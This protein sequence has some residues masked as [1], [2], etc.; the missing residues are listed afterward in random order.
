MAE[1]KPDDKRNRDE[2]SQEE[3]PQDTQPENQPGQ[4][5]SSNESGD[6]LEESPTGFVVVDPDTN[7]VLESSLDPEK[8]EDSITIGVNEDAV[9][10]QIDDYTDDPDVLNDFAERQ[11]AA[12]VGS[13]VLLDS[14]VE[15]H[16]RSPEVSGGDIDADW[17]G[18]YQSG[19]E[20][21][22]GTVATPDQDIV[23][24]LGEAV[25]L[26]YEDDEPL[27][28]VEK[29]LNRDQDRWELD[30]KSGEEQEDALDLSEDEDIE[31]LLESEDV[32]EDDLVAVTVDLE[33]E[34][35]DE[36]D[37]DLDLIDEEVD[38]ADLDVLDEEEVAEE[39]E[40]EEFLD[41]EDD[42]YDEDEDDDFDFD[43]D[44]FE[45]LFDDEDD[46]Y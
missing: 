41:E 46:D 20:S 39:D 23:E 17:E 30:P 1:K 22:G 29:L 45:D 26:E 37:L 19:E 5:R 13:Q 36:E 2:K 8:A 32:D 10:D 15:H 33:D 31:D 43:D 27:G 9:M 21:V 3:V 44:D 34:D 7:E 24:D 4:G 38:E 25:G 6:Q 14:L 28:T 40:E 42:L 12:G 11:Q 18:T 35:E 16:S